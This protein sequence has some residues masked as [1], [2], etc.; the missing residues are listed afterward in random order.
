MR[1]VRDESPQRPE[2]PPESLRSSRQPAR[3]TGRVTGWDVVI[4]VII[5]VLA[6][7]WVALKVDLVV[8]LLRDTGPTPGVPSAGLRTWLWG[9]S[10]ALAAFPAT[11]LLVAVIAVLAGLDWVLR[12]VR[13]NPS[14]CQ[15]EDRR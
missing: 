5:G 15:G 10:P 8:G 1:Q 2:R 3:G 13:G 6:L 12:R 4:F 9:I 14:P 7:W 11:S